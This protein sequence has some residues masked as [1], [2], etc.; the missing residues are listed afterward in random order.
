LK[1]QNLTDF[2][3]HIYHSPD[4]NESGFWS[5]MK[6]KIRTEQKCPACGGKF[7]LTYRG[8][9]C[10][11]HKRI[12]PSK[13]YLEWWLFGEHFREFGFD[14]FKQAALHASSLEE[15]ITTGRFKPQ[16]HKGR[17]SAG[18]KRFSFTECYER[19]LIS[20]EK[21]AN[22]NRLSPGYVRKLKNEKKRFVEFFGNEDVRL[23]RTFRINDFY[24]SLS[25]KIALKT[26][27]NIMSVLRKFFTDM[28]DSEL[29]SELP[30]FPKIKPQNPTIEWIDKASQ[31]LILQE[32][33]EHHKPIF[34]FMFETGCRPAEARA[35]LWS[36][37]DLANDT[38][39]IRH[40]F[41][42][43]VHRMITKG[44]TERVLPLSP[45]LKKT[46][47][48]Q[49]KVLRSEFV[50]HTRFGKSIGQ[51]RLRKIW[52]QACKDAKVSGIKLYGGTRH[53]FA[54]Q[55]LNEGKPKD[56]IAEWLGHGDN[57]TI[58]KY[59]HVNLE[60]MKKILDKD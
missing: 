37:V 13:F 29:I 14:S 30:R 18:N 1:N 31:L 33:P 20:R 54:S 15:E 60:G 58:N 59:S 40:S 46:L 51:N 48:D 11:E 3:N 23:I 9:F 43:A 38:V 55:N 50:F 7:I 10:T 16:L 44:K 4:E 2:Q 57:N 56:L 32:I 35:L 21:D 17:R 8:M 24:D 25:E 34:I 39:V 28:F 52:V 36:S 42:D 19:W 45:I 12:S 49:P 5:D 6:V 53:S 26:Q 27:K 41:S 22:K 47:Q